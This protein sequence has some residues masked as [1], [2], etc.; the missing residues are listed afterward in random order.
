MRILIT[1]DIH[2]NPAWLN[3]L[4]SAAQGFDL[5]VI[6][7]DVFDALDGGGTVEQAQDFDRFLAAIK[8]PCVAFT[9]GNHDVLTTETPQEGSQRMLEMIVAKNWWDPL[10]KP[11]LVIVPGQ[12]VFLPIGLVVSTHPYRFD[13]E[14]EVGDGLLWAEGAKLRRQNRCPWLAV[15]HE[16][17]VRTLVGERDGPPSAL[18]EAIDRWQPNYLASGH[19]H[20]RPFDTDG[21]FVDRVEAT[22]CFNP[23]CCHQSPAP[24]HI[25]LD[26]RSGT[27]EWRAMYRAN[28]NP[29]IAH[30]KK[31]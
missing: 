6:A 22:V 19:L 25:V 20:N 21:A 18:E 4:C 15:H 24:N 11:G 30:I 12:A 2:N 1:A 17:P 29:Q 16:P 5:L 9:S 3:F 14:N 26:T 10:A 13:S 28:G 31:L 23:G 27:A 8:G 7:G